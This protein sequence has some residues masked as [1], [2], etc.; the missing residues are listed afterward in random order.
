METFM[1]LAS[2]VVDYFLFASA[3]NQ[4]ILFESS[5]LYPTI[6]T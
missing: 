3:V 5:A 1:V 4:Y 6:D 2:Y